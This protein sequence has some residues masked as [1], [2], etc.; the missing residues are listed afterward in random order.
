MFRLALVVMS[1]A[2]LAGCTSNTSLNTLQISQ[3]N[4]AFPANYRD[5]AAK[6]IKGR[7]VQTAG[8]T[9]SA[10]RPVFGANAFSAQR[11]FV[12]V[13]GTPKPEA[14]TAPVVI[15]P[16]M[17]GSVELKGHTKPVVV[18]DPTK[19]FEL[20]VFFNEGNLASVRETS[21]AELCRDGVYEPL[22]LSA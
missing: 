21:E 16:F 2:V 18:V 3:E 10:P 19:D 4:Q 14:A 1:V 22:K 7:P 11:W 5:V 6:A 8:L 12:C 15:A 17:V 20:L 9:V 13:V